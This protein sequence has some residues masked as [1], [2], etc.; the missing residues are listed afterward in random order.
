MIYFIRYYLSQDLK[1]KFEFGLFRIVKFKVIIYL[2]LA[3]FRPLKKRIVFLFFFGTTRESW[4]FFIFFE[5]GRDLFLETNEEHGTCGEGCDHGHGGGWGWH[6]PWVGSSE[7]GSD[8]REKEEMGRY[9][10]EVGVVL[11]AMVFGRNIA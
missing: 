1:I 6:F 7:S 11:G 2:W 3:N 5:V 8:L 4:I 9:Q 10:T